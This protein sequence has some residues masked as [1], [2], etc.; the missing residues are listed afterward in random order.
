MR[1]ILITILIIFGIFEN[2]SGQRYNFSRIFADRLFLNPALSGSLICPEINFNH[3]STFF[4][5]DVLYSSYSFSYDQYIE[6]IHGGIG[7]HTINNSQAKGT[8]NFFN[9]TGIYSYH[10]KISGKIKL[11]YGFSILYNQFNINTNKLIFSDMINPFSGEIST[12][13]TENN[14]LTNKKNIDFGSS[15]AIYTRKIH[16]G[17]SL[18]NASNL[19]YKKNIHN[20]PASFTFYLGRRFIL[21]AG[22]I[23]NKFSVMPCFGYKSDKDFRQLFSGILIDN[24]KI[25][26]GFH[27][28]NNLEF[29]SFSLSAFFEFKIK[30][31]ALSVSYEFYILKYTNVPA[32]NLQ[33]S[34]RY[35]IPCKTKRN[36][37]NTIYCTPF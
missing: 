11:N 25:S 36:R 14:I 33:L 18:K 13:V 8:V 37:N 20:F 34:L 10:T 32:G 15:V 35:K 7:F 24:K 31:Y 1:I 30:S 23:N 26:T 2:L 3:Q 28:K 16:F 27:V 6:K 17:I 22:N 5:N 4:A 9:I 29:N 19:F 21:P 12:N